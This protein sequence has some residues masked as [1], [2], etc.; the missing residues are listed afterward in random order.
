MSPWCACH[1]I[2]W[3][4][5][6]RYI[7]PERRRVREAELIALLDERP[8]KLLKLGTALGF[9]AAAMSACLRRSTTATFRS[10]ARRRRHH[11]AD[12]QNTRSTRL[13][14]TDLT[15]A[16]NVISVISDALTAKDRRGGLVIVNGPWGSGK[17]T[18]VDEALK[19]I[20]GPWVVKYNPWAWAMGADGMGTHGMTGLGRSIR[21]SS[22]RLAG[23]AWAFERYLR[24]LPG[25]AQAG[26]PEPDQR[27][28]RRRLERQLRR[29]SRPI[30]IA[31]DD[32]DRIRPCEAT[33][34]VR[35]VART[36]AL[37]QL[38]YILS[39]DG[40]VMEQELPSALVG[41]AGSKL[42][43]DLNWGTCRQRPS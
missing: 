42:Q 5:R 25:S 13:A 32:I 18:L 40:S 21:G 19:I 30:V 29:L 9:L 2:R 15:A 22:L 23:V 34:V 11:L 20:H 26:S 17:T 24:T 43:V 3:S 41:P 33:E 36:A 31:I 12:S 4:V 14:L 8:G 7:E 37:P 39:F 16:S 27:R 38:R 10:F 35:L 6:L 28:A 1:L